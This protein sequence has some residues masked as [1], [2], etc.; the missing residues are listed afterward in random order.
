MFF[1]RLAFYVA[2][3]VF[4]ALHNIYF[5]RLWHDTAY[6][7]FMLKVPLNTNN[8]NHARL[9]DAHYVDAKMASVLQRPPN[10]TVRADGKVRYKVGHCSSSQRLQSM[11]V[12]RPEQH[13]HLV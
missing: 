3:Y 5:I 2:V 9:R 7:V 12:R 11:I 4:P 8:H 13:Q 10:K 6:L 1:F